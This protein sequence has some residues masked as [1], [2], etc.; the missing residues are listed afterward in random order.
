MQHQCATDISTATAASTSC[1]GISLNHPRDSDACKPGLPTLSV[2]PNG[3]QR[4][5]V[6]TRGQLTSFLVINDQQA[7][8]SRPLTFTL[9]PMKHF[10][11]PSV[12]SAQAK[13][14]NTTYQVM[15]LWKY[16][17]SAEL[18]ADR[19][20]AVVFTSG[21][22]TT[23]CLSSNHHCLTAR[24][25]AATSPAPAS[26]AVSQHRTAAAVK[27]QLLPPIG[28]FQDHRYKQFKGPFQDQPNLQKTINNCCL[29]KSQTKS[30][31]PPHTK[32]FGPK[33]KK[34]SEWVGG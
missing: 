7:G 30:I 6:A 12:A 20:T 24:T 29:K 8:L 31:T 18:P 3:N 33:H 10:N 1:K 27:P 26:S 34:M 4:T 28:P 21:H 19:H 16:T 11:P 25:S 2:E 14:V 17:L 32:H 23:S 22:A 5:A 15:L 13:K 9:M